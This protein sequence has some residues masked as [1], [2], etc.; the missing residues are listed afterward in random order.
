MAWSRQTKPLAVEPPTTATDERDVRQVKLSLKVRTVFHAWQLLQKSESLQQ[1]F[2]VSSPTA[3]GKEV[4][5][6]SSP[7]VLN[8]DERAMRV[9]LANTPCRKKIAPCS[10]GTLKVMPV[11]FFSRNGLVLDHPVPVG[12]TV[13]GPYYCSLLQDKVRP[14]LCRK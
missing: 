6:K 7:H 11:M 5:A 4:F 1:V 13:N 3:G 10:Q 9:H 2:T 12:T 14:A 8:D